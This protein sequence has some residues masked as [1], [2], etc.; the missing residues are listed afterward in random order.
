MSLSI[1]HV[2]EPLYLVK[3]GHSEK[4]GKGLDFSPMEKWG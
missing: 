1:D 2:H 4:P 3:H